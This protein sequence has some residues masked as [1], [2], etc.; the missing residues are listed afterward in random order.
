MRATHTTTHPG[1]LPMGGSAS[2]STPQPAAAAVAVAAAQLAYHKVVCEWPLRPAAPP[3]FVVC[4]LAERD[5][6]LVE[7]AAVALV[8]ALWL[9]QLSSWEQPGFLA[10][11]S[12]L[13][14]CCYCQL[15]GGTCF[16]FSVWSLRDRVSRHAGIV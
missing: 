9:E 10:C 16:L 12:L 11:S 2:F 15:V 3:P 7:G 13:H 6:L 14:A 8:I 5:S 4:R 1:T